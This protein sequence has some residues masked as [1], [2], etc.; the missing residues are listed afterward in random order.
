[1]LLNGEQMLKEG[2]LPRMRIFTFCVREAGGVCLTRC[3]HCLVLVQ[4]NGDC[5]GDVF[6]VFMG[7]RMPLLHRCRLRLCMFLWLLNRRLAR[8]RSLLCLS[9]RQRWSK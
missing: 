5:W 6:R 1:M 2:L 9:L 8:K 7:L 3:L 4:F